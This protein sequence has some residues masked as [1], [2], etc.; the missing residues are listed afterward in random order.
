M[1]HGKTGRLKTENAKTIVSASAPYASISL[2][3]RRKF[4]CS[5]ERGRATGSGNQSESAAL[6]MTTS[7][8]V[9]LTGN[10]TMIVQ[11]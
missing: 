5:S 6:L 2:R 7:K 10:R 9:S 8:N 1:A 4:L 3:K 11:S